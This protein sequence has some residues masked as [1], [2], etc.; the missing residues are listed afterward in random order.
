M[1][2]SSDRLE[3]L[4]AALAEARRHET[5][6]DL[7]LD[8]VAT[9]E[10]AEAVQAAAVEAYG[11]S[12]IGYSIQGTS[13]QTG[14]QLCCAEPIF[15][16]L[17]DSELLSNGSRFRLPRGV[18]GAGCSF[19]FG[20]GRPYPAEGEEIDRGS[21]AEAV[22][23]CR[24]AIEILGR[25]VPGSVPLNALT[26]TADFA[27]SV[28]HIEGPHIQ[29]LADMDLA[30]ARSEAKINGK[31]VSV[32]RGADIMNHPLEAIAWLAKELGRHGRELD[33]GDL[34]ATGSCTGILQVMPG[35]VF[36]ADFGKLGRVSVVFE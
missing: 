20:I 25:R 15:G 3:A 18:F 12:P 19:V 33:A 28:L 27:M 17:L 5:V 35:Q 9:L 6:K 31:T 16:P 2:L 8:R 36:E 1:E 21:I 14:R 22:A 32:G 30:A 34:V 7:P 13:A 11:G 4:G 29:N 23:D 24:L 26:A 10:E